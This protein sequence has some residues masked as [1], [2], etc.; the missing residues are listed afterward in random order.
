VLPAYGKI[1]CRECFSLTDGETTKPHPEWRMINDPGAW[2]GSIPKYLVLGFSKGSTQAGIYQNGKF[3]DIAYAGM[4]PRLTVALQSMGV[5]QN[6]ETV[7]E[8]IGDPESNIHLAH[9]SDVACLG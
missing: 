1:Q 2:G 3:E 8:K 7:D 6:T 5:L 9:L 4:R